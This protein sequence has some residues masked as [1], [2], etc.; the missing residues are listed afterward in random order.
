MPSIRDEKILFQRA[1]SDPYGA[2]GEPPGEPSAPGLGV[3]EPRPGLS[4]ERVEDALE[5]A[6]LRDAVG[7]LSEQERR[8]LAETMV[9][10]LAEGHELPEEVNE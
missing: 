6:R 5:Q 9:A 10:E 8:Q 3:D 1:S 7:K 4:V 2:A